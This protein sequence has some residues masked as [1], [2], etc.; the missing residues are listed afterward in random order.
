MVLFA[1]SGVHLIRF[2]DVGFV[3]WLCLM[4]RRTRKK[5]HKGFLVK[6]NCYDS[7][8]VVVT[9]DPIDGPISPIL[10]G[11]GGGV[12]SSSRVTVGSWKI[13]ALV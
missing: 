9:P 4:L 7:S 11:T 8:K 5:R 2:N 12:P 3:K 6:L 13:E 10:V 1:A